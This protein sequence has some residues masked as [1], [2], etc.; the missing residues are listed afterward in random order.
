[1]PRRCQPD[2]SRP[3]GRRPR[4]ARAVALGLFILGGAGLAAP[5]AA[6]TGEPG[7]RRTADVD[8]HAPLAV[9]SALTFK[10]L[11]EI[12]LGAHPRQLELGARSAEAEAWRDRSGN[13]LAAAPSLY[14]SYLSDRPL[15]ARDQREYESGVELPLWRPGQ[16]SAARAV[17]ESAAA[18]SDAARAALALDVAGVL[19]DVLWDIEAAAVELAA[20]EESRAVAAELLEAVERLHARG[21]LPLADVLLAQAALLEREQQLVAQQAM[22]V[23]AEH[24]YAVFTGL[25]RRPAAFLETL[26][27]RAGYD[28]AHPLLALADAEV[29]RA[30]SDFDLAGRTVRGAPTLSIGP[31]RERDLGATLYNDGISVAVRVPVGGKSHGATQ[32]ASDARAVAA[33]TSARGNRLRSLELALHEAEHALEVL[34]RSIGLAETRRE[35]ASR[36][37]QMARTAFAE[38]EIEVRDLLRIQDAA[39]AASREAERLAVERGRAIAAYNQAVGEIP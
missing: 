18:E 31:W 10:G 22:L 29:E 38:G 1:M 24:E 20:A 39:Q 30:R 16:R 6:Q 11:L 27:T 23:D 25:D 4:L 15:D 14:F 35:L 26:S 5:A 28:A 7:S 19:R 33:A 8:R 21:E 3:R 9:D 12:A 32:I 13:L 17:A 2:P 34:E 36:Q 37:W